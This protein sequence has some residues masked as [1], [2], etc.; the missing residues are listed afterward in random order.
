MIIKNCS[1]SFC[2]N[3][4]NLVRCGLEETILCKPHQVMWYKYGSATPVF[5][6]K[7]CQTSYIFI[8][9]RYGS[10]SIYC[11]NCNEIFNNLLQDI[12]VKELDREGMGHMDFQFGIIMIFGNLKTRMQ[13]VI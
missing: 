12:E 13:F 2:D 5:K 10:S 3:T 7:R 6:C 11:N 8:G 9:K 1:V 4:S